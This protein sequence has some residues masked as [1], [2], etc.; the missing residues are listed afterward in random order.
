MTRKSLKAFEK[1]MRSFLTEK[2]YL[3]TSGNDGTAVLRTSSKLAIALKILAGST[4]VDVRWAFRVCSATVYNLFHDTVNNLVENL[5]I[6][7]CSTTENKLLEERAMAFKTSRKNES[8]FDGCVGALD[9]I[10]IPI[11]M[12]RNVSNPASFY[13]RKDFYAI[14]V[15]AV[16]DTK[17][18][19]ISFQQT[20]SDPI[21]MQL[22]MPCR[23]SEGSYRTTQFHLD[24]GSPRMMLTDV[25]TTSRLRFPHTLKG[26]YEVGFNV[27]KAP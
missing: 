21:M 27:F 14:P 26:A 18:R 12:P 8:P 20:S 4:Y 5:E 1:E 22:H 7:P 6:E 23:A 10:A 15:Q 16:V 9:G 19:F 13:N 24:S 25:L 3:E 2:R 11:E 17:F